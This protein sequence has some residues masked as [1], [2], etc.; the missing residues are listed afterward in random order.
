V[1]TGKQLC[2]ALPVAQDIACFSF[3]L[4]P[5]ARLRVGRVVSATAIARVLIFM[6]GLLLVDTPKL[7]RLGNI[8]NTLVELRRFARGFA[9]F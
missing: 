9:F 6:V 5:M 3:E 8:S 4:H 2:E 7:H 1:L